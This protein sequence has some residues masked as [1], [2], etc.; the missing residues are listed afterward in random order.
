MKI[1]DISTPANSRTILWPGNAGLTVKTVARIGGTHAHNESLIQM[2]VHTATHIDAPLHFIKNGQSID[3]V[4]LEHC[5]G[6]A[7]VV[8]VRNKKEITEKDVEGLEL[9]KGITRILFKTSNS[10]RWKKKKFDEQYVGLTPA[11]S[12]ALVK[13]KIKLVG[14]DYLSIA[15]FSDA[16][17]VHQ[18][19]LG[20]KIVILEGI[21][22]SKV[23]VGKYELVCLPVCLTNLEAAP[24]RAILLTD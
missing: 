11:A 18:I 23:K 16:Q 2:N 22:L 17:E 19:L 4:N 24:T 13:K 9:P 12:R 15:K 6:P 20:N 5:I 14:I 1:I 7:Y 3:N 8:E 21:N 10:A